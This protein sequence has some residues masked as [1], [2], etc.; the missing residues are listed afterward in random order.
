MMDEVRAQ[1]KETYLRAYT[2]RT[3]QPE[4]AEKLFREVMQLLP[5]SEEFA[6][7]A[8]EQLHRLKGRIS[9]EE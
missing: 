6:Q 5:K 4:Q 1:A 3:T 7:K 9:D 8:Q 2:L